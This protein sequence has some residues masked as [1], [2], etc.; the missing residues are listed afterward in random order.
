MNYHD[1]S[2]QLDYIRQS[3]SQNKKHVG[4]FIGAGC[5]LAV[6]V[7]R[8]LEDG[9]TVNEPI[10]P[11]VAG[12]TN[13]IATKLKTPAGEEESLYDRLAKL[14]VE[15]EKA[16]FNI[17]DALSMIRSMSQVV[18]KGVVRGFNAA[19]LELLDRSICEIISEIVDQNLPTKESP[20]HDLAIWARSLS[21][22]KPVHIFTTN[23]D[24][25]M[26]E[27]LEDESA[28]YFDGFIGSRNAFF[29]LGAVEN[30]KLIGPRWLRLWKIHGSINWKLKLSQNAAAGSVIRSD[31]IESGQKHLIYPSHLKF[32]QSRKMPYLALMDRLKDFISCPS[33][34]LFMSG[35]SFSDDHINDIIVSSLKNNP[36]AM[37][38]AF[39]FGPL[40]GAGYSKAIECGKQTP[41]LVIAAQDEA[42]IGRRRA[43]W[44]SVGE[45]EPGGLAQEVIHLLGAETDE[46]E[47]R[48]PCQLNL[49][50]FAKLGL[51]LRSLSRDEL[52]STTHE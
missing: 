36:T 5:P 25:L 40:A 43:G 14:F 30:E 21:R 29:D 27:A 47:G 37:V 32:D 33:S 7:E 18:G 39:L 24:L 31:K 35:Y 12:L 16:Q 48:I 9:Q 20:Y 38:H 42:I 17:E 45:S 2:R 22:D 26:E 6:H 51:L 50:D 10:I 13:M 23:Y 41:N 4:F 52:Q 49:G 19:D 11:D 1:A 15:D 46:N 44:V 28:P 3:L 34:L 8:Q